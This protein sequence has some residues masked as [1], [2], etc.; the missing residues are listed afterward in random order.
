MI[1]YTY[2]KMY[3][4][5]EKALT[6]NSKKILGDIVLT[7]RQYRYLLEIAKNRIKQ[8]KRSGWNATYDLV[9]AVALVKIGAYQYESG[10]YWDKMQET[11]GIKLT[12]NDTTQLGVLFITTLEKHRLYIYVGNNQHKNYYVVNILIHG[13][14]PNDYLPDFFE[15]V[16]AFYELNLGRD[17]RDMRDDLNTLLEFIKESI[18]H[19]SRKDE[20][21]LGRGR[22]AQV[23]RLRKTTKIAMVSFDRRAKNMIRR[24]IKLIDTRYWEGSLPQKPSSRFTKQFLYWA[25]TSERFIAATKQRSDQRSKGVTMF[26][27]PYYHYNF[28]NDQFYLVI[29]AQKF[30]RND[31]TN[32]IH[33]TIQSEFANKITK[34]AVYEIFG[35]YKSEEK[36]IQISVLELFSGIQITIT[37]DVRRIK[38]FNLNLLDYICLDQDGIQM[39]RLK[40]GICHFVAKKDF[41]LNSEDILEIRQFKNYTLYFLSVNEETLHLLNGQPL[42]L[43]QSY[44]E[45]IQ[46]KG[47]ITGITASAS[48][49]NN[50]SNNIPVYNKPPKLII[51][52]NSED[53]HGVGLLLNGQRYRITGYL[54]EWDAI[55]FPTLDGTEQFIAQIDFRNL[56]IQDGRYE[57]IIDTPGLSKKTPFEFLYIDNFQYDF[58]DSPYF[59][60]D[61]AVCNI[62]TKYSIHAINGKYRGNG[63]Y[64]LSLTPEMQYAQ[65]V[66]N[67]DD[68]SYNLD[69]TIPYF[70]WRTGDSSWRI[71]QDNSLWYRELGQDI[72]I[73]LPY[74]DEIMIQLNRDSTKQIVECPR[75]SDGIYIFNINKF[76]NQIHDFRGHYSLDLIIDGVRREWLQILSKNKVAFALLT[77]NYTKGEITGR[78]DIQGEAPCVASIVHLDTQQKLVDNVTIEDGILHANQLFTQG[79]YR[80]MVYQIEDDVFGFGETR[81]QLYKK[82][83]ELV[84][85]YD[86]SNVQILLN[87]VGIGVFVNRLENTYCIDNLNPTQSEG[88]YTGRVYILKNQQKI[89][90]D[91]LGVVRMIFRNIDDLTKAHI[92]TKL[93]DE[94]VDLMLDTHHKKLVLEEDTKIPKR[95]A[96]RIYKVLTPEDTTFRIQVRRK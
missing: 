57:V 33:I 51:K 79:K 86:L 58:T 82:D 16:Y 95:T 39:N 26:T 85:P 63:I 59:F 6:N 93:D 76:K 25:N 56:L 15:F 42:D 68:D 72:T 21:Q 22:S 80:V 45:G 88:T 36:K 55:I 52:S 7:P 29:P 19:S 94:W 38:S 54:V 66:I 64:L 10:N 17:T 89:P 92:L 96:Y 83:L 34:L 62:N 71:D 50:T 23:Y 40:V 35:G 44:K 11:L 49:D 47:L 90:Y 14:V 91:E 41:I 48:D 78:F 9:I 74:Q 5:F 8:L 75:V 4:R 12:T 60:S 32:E 28:H 1:K 84:D 65:F 87:S 46:Q 67:I 24:I 43:S 81:I 27:S 53:F 69:I 77:A 3:N 61:I 18:E 30:R 73:D 13:I 70:R 2:D 37:S 31:I 20:V